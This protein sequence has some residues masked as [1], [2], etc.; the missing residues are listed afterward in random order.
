MRFVTIFAATAALLAMTVQD[1][2]AISDAD[3]AAAATC[4]AATRNAESVERIPRGLLKAISLKES[5]RWDPERKRSYAWPWT[6]TSGG[7]GTHY[8]TKSEAISAVKELQEAGRTNID[9]G[10]MQIN[11]H[12]HPHAFTSL[13]DA[14]DPAKNA[15]YAAAHLHQLREDYKSWPTA[16]ERYHS[17]DP[18]RGKAYRTAVYKLKTKAARATQ[19]AAYEKSGATW[20]KRLERQRE[21][22]AAARKIRH[23]RIRKLNK[24]KNAQ[25]KRLR[26]AFEERRAKVMR[27][28]KEMMEKRWAALRGKRSG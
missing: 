5:G 18:E 11:L 12:Y 19:T 15:G 21:K 3:R 22:Y 27:E 10:C 28:W 24:T 25:N 4:D 20:K 6:V 9:V 14:F 2:A 16:V 1:A 26:A 8:K 23:D 7:S 17:G 13:D